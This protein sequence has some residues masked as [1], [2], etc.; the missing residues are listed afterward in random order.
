MADEIVLKYIG[1]GGF[2]PDVPAR[3]LTEEEVKAAGGEKKLLESG[4]YEPVKKPARKVDSEVT[5]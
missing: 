3:A 4:L 1:N 5:K 2:L